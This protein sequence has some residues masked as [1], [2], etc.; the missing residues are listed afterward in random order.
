MF[1][2]RDVYG[3]RAL[4]GNVHEVDGKEVHLGYFHNCRHCHDGL[5]HRRKI[6]SPVEEWWYQKGSGFLKAGTRFHHRDSPVWGRD[7]QETTCTSNLG[8]RCQ[9]LAHQRRSVKTQVPEC[10]G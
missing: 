1:E 3:K 2:R 6:T 7:C 4:R 10:H 5:S 8:M 9:T